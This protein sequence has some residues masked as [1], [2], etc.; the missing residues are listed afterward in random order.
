MSDRDFERAFSRIA[1]QTNWER[2]P[3]KRRHRFDLSG[4]QGLLERLGRPDRRLRCVVQVGG[5]KGK[6]TVVSV[7]DGLARAS[8]LRSV[9]YLS[10]H[11]VDV[12]ERVRVDGRDVDGEL[13]A[14]AL[15]R[16]ADEMEPGQTWFEVFTAAAV[17]AFAELDPDLCVL[18]VGLGGRLDSTTAIDKRACAITSV[19]IEHAQV[20]GDTVREVAGEKAGI[21]RAGV[22]C[23]TST[24]C[25]ALDVVE[26]RARELDIPLRVMDRDYGVEILG[27]GPSGMRVR[28]LSA[29]ESCELELPLRTE[30]HARAY[31]TAREL[32]GLAFPQLAAAAPGDWLADALP[33]GRFDVR[34]EAPPLVIDGAHTEAS[35]LALCDELSANF[36]RQRF[37]LVFGVARGKRWEAGLGRLLE[38]VDRV[39]VAPLDDKQSVDTD[40]LRDFVAERDRPCVV[41]TTIRDAFEQADAFARNE[42]CGLVVTGSLYA[43][44]DALRALHNQDSLTSQ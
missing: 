39:W 30:M 22:P 26:A 36:P 42:D 6:G 35:L 31:A 25:E 27:R 43:A 44:G 14:P 20:L 23:V 34:R 19:E 32:F 1:S 8:G 29:G 5:S 2:K 9:A 12:R 16:V 13:L 38:L 7:L 4:M 40:V 21:L 11:V 17:L 18:E 41:C 3:S 37:V 28:H 33:P 10:P 24:S 15:D